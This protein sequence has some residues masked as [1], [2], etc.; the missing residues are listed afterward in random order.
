[1][2]LHV[3]VYFDYINAFKWSFS[4]PLHIHILKLLLNGLF[5]LKYTF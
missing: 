1:M 3:K 4:N 2:L 5:E